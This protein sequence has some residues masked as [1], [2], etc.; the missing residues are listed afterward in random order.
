MRARN[1]ILYNDSF[2]LLLIRKQMHK[3]LMAM[4]ATIIKLTEGLLC[5]RAMPSLS[6]QLS[7]QLRKVGICVPPCLT[8][9]PRPSETIIFKGR[10]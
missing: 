4:V 8:E 10:Q 6:F 2:C 7:E 9:Q 1:Q 3:K 5:A